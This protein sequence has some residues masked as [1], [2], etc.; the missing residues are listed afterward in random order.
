MFR[1]V[2]IRRPLDFYA[3]KKFISLKNRCSS[4]TKSNLFGNSATNSSIIAMWHRCSSVSSK[5]QM[6]KLQNRHSKQL[7][8]KNSLPIIPSQ[9]LIINTRVRNF[10][11]IVVYIEVSLN[12]GEYCTQGSLEKDITAAASRAEPSLRAR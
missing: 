10:T 1:H 3:I 11:Y 8:A 4:H 2:Q 7:C 12:S 6:C 5:L 9:Q